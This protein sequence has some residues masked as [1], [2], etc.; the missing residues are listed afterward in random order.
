MVIRDSS[1]VVGQS[2]TSY[3]FIS[4]TL[5]KI[6]ALRYCDGSNWINDEK[7]LPLKEQVMFKIKIPKDIIG[8]VYLGDFKFMGTMNLDNQVLLNR[9]CAF[10]I[11]KISVEQ[12]D[13]NEKVN[14]FD[15]D[16]VSIDE[17]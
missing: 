7:T 13:R 6:E 11:N 4:T 15:V 10:K 9:Y 14:V 1:G 5:D 12:N 8:A 16:L 17:K 2:I 3:G